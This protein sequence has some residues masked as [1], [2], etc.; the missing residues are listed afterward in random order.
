MDLYAACPNHMNPPL[1]YLDPTA[2]E[3]LKVYAGIAPVSVGGDSIAGTIIAETRSPQFAAPGQGSLFAGE[4]GTFYRSNGD[5]HGANLALTYATEAFNVSYTGAMAQ[6]DDY[7]AGGEFKNYDFTGRLGHTLARDVV[8]STAYETRNH[9]LGFA[10]KG[11]P[12][13]VEARLGYQ[14][15]PVQL[16]PNQRM[17]MLDNEQKRVNLRYRGRFD[18]GSLE[19]RAWHE[20]VDHFMDFGAD[21]RYWYGMASG[22]GTAVDGKPC[23]PV[24]SPNCAAGMPMYT[25]SKT[26][27]ASVRADWAMSAQDLLRLG[28]ELHR[29]RL[30]DWWP[31][32]GGGMFPGTFW[33]IRAGERE[34]TALFAEW[35][36][37][38]G[39]QWTTLLGARVE[40]VR[41]NAGEVHGYNPAGGG[42][43][44]RDAALFNAGER[45][46]RDEN[47]D[48]TALAR[49]RH[50]ATLDIEF[51][52][53][54][55]VRSPSLYEAYP[56]STWQ[57]AALMNNFVGDGNGYVGNPA[58]KPEK[59]HTLSAS[60][61]WHAA[62]RGWQ[63]RVMPYYTR[64]S[65]FIDAV[66]WNATTNA[67]QQPLLKDRF[68]VLRYANQ[69]ARL[70]GL[71]FSGRMPLARTAVG[72]F[73]FKGVLDVTRG[74]NLSTGDNLYNI[75]PLNGRLTLTHKLGG[76][77]NA[78]ELVLVKAKDRVSSMRN[79]LRT[80]GYGLVH[81]RASY[82]WKQVRVDFGIENLFDKHY[83]LPLGG[84]YTGQG[85]TMTNPPLPNYPQWGTPVP[86][87]GR[88]FYVGLNMK[89]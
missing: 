43:Q 81:L 52:W 48:L 88:S 86:G 85:T 3:V 57:M 69:S 5:A 49:Y 78:I 41:L 34:R 51:G 47:L 82:G 67:P 18:W 31:P 63:F 59:A 40:Q 20:T 62:D 16:Y 46:R 75:M 22:G 11:G 77:D 54:R 28:L 21:K 58:L 72:D 32:S 61:D 39:S 14:D 6:A 33:N 71:D 37:Q 35:E 1:S 55:K 2:V 27:G 9:T 29:Y 64:V 4:V 8:G 36:G 10:L 74:K 26:D 44:G 45:A 68:T 19:A 70:Y 17:D 50:D 24:P 76:W 30:D 65:D 38:L 60:F 79:E 25:A 87:M 7:K 12:H 80:P 53:A 66:Q 23:A 15:L 42:N 13:R 73:G 83:Y 56:W 84:A 89:F